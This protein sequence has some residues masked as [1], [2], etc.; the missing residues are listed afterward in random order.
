MASKKKRT[1]PQSAAP[2]TQMP[3]KPAPS[4]PAPIETEPKQSDAAAANRLGLYIAIF[5]IVAILAIGGAFVWLNQ[6]N[7]TQGEP[8]LNAGWAPGPTNMC[9]GTPKFPIEKLGFSRAVVFSTSER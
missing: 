1:P 7:T 5:G 3:A 4:K 9:R 8:I 2:P 6:S